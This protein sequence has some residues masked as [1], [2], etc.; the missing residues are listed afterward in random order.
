[1]TKT[2]SVRLDSDIKEKAEAILELYGLDIS[3]FLLMTIHATVNQGAIPYEIKYNPKFRSVASLTKE[4]I[5]ANST[6][7]GNWIFDEEEGRF[8]RPEI[9]DELEKNGDYILPNANESIED[10][11][12]RL[13]ANE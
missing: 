9:I 7:D 1:M 3:T 5:E 10:F 4:E 11:M 2:L 12:K 13:I 8:I 6:E